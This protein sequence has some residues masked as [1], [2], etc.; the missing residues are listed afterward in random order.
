[1]T[2]E[3]AAEMIRRAYG[4]THRTGLMMIAKIVDRVD[5]TQDEITAGI[6]HLMQ[7][8]PRVVVIPES[9]QKVLTEEERDAAVT[10]GCQ[11]KHLIGW[12]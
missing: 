4:T 8:D 1:M 2:T 3:K 11:V 7:T 6:I 10:I 9:N 12:V 5:L